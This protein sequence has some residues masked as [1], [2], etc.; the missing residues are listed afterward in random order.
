MSNGAE[1]NNKQWDEY[2]NGAEWLKNLS[3]DLKQDPSLRDFKDP[4]ALAKSYVELKK[5]S[6][7]SIR[8][9]ENNDPRE[10]HVKF[11][12][13]IMQVDGII[14][15]PNEKDEESM[16]KFYNRLGRPENAVEYQFSENTST[17]LK[18]DPE[19]S[20]MIK[21]VFHKA[22]LNQKQANFLLEK[23]IGERPVVDV[24]KESYANL[25][26]SLN[27]QDIQPLLDKSNTT[28]EAIAEDL[29]E[30]K[31]LMQDYKFRYNPAIVSIF[32]EMKHKSKG[33][34]AD[35]S[36][37]PVIDANTGAEGEGTYSAPWAK[38]YGVK[39]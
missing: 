20:E 32:A 23:F 35:N 19:T 7:S 15:L 26:K 18:S 14:A 1:N 6:G 25:K 9:P 22:G 29:P 3:D 17:M 39:M 21:E 36:R 30:L 34:Q 33:K 37:T 13:K 24:E 8:F 5:M 12:D 2:A 31:L 16:G 10:E 11:L 4:N 28:M 27:T 38:E